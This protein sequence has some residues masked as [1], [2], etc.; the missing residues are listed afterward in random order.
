MIYRPPRSAKRGVRYRDVPGAHPRKGHIPNS[1]TA[2]DRQR[3]GKRVCI[4]VSRGARQCLVPREAAK[5]ARGIAHVRHGNITHC[6]QLKIA[7][8]HDCTL[9][10]GL[11][12]ASRRAP[13]IEMHGRC[14]GKPP[15]AHAGLMKPISST[16]TAFGPIGTFR[17]FGRLR[18]MNSI[19]S[20]HT[21][22]KKSSKTWI[23]SCSPGQR[24]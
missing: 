20:F 18:L 3:L 10:P 12:A 21:L 1:T 23:V 15:P 9:M 22:R 7:Q 17:G 6:G 11:R 8:F 2:Q 4:D 24:R 5:V 16:I 14:N 13:V 19:L